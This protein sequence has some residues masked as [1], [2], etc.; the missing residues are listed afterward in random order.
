MKRKFFLSSYLKKAIK[1]KKPALAHLLDRSKIIN[2]MEL[3]RYNSLTIFNYHRIFR[4]NLS[5]CFDEKVFGTSEAD[6]EKQMHWLKENKA[7]FLSEEEVVSYYKAEKILPQRSVL[8]TF[9][10]GYK[11]N[12]DL[13][14]PVLKSLEIPA[15]YFLPTNMIT[16]R[17]LC[18]WDLISF[19]IKKTKKKTIFVK[20]KEMSLTNEQER[21]KAIDFLL[22]LMKREK[23]SYT[24]DLLDVLSVECEVAFPSLGEQDAQLMS[25]KEVKEI[26]GHG[27]SI[28]SHTNS[29]R[30]L[31]TLDEK[32]Q[33]EE[34][35]SSKE[36]LEERLS[37]RIRSISYPVGDYTA[38]TDTT[39][40]LAKRAGYDLGFSFKTGVNYSYITDPFDVKRLEPADD[41]ITFKSTVIAPRIFSI[42]SSQ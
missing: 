9:D 33:F 21:E 31:A 7:V 19:F 37:C 18:W 42:R 40:A 8:I 32:T 6:F 35:Q 34:L 13:A 23:E 27:V 41:F 26:M 28:G 1:G 4:N 30:V 5:T 22:Q 10:D 17:K 36:I 15:I 20:G 12:F 39:K 29:H 3:F 11:D 14:F 38:F 25:W 24:Q 16:E 2:V